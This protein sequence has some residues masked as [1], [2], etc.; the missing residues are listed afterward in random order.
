MVMLDTR[1]H[2]KSK[3][4]AYRSLVFNLTNSMPE[5][6]IYKDLFTKET[7]SKTVSLSERPQGTPN[8][9]VAIIADESFRVTDWNAI[10]DITSELADAGV[11][12]LSYRHEKVFLP[13]DGRPKN[14]IVVTAH[15]DQQLAKFVD[16]LGEMGA[17]RGNYILFNSCGTRL[18]GSLV[19]KINQQYGAIATYSY[20]DV[21]DRGRVQDFVYELTDAVRNQTEPWRGL[22]GLVQQLTRKNG[23]R[24]IWTVS[25]LGEDLDYARG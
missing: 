5:A 22:S 14:V 7:L 3:S 17:F 12:V 13:T 2:D 9:Y 19:E 10:Q 25:Q 1:L 18:T 6:R 16:S 8:D 20:D 21:I 11:Q 23:L 4:S 24:G 15:S